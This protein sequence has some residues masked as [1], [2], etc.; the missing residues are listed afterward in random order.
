MQ[1]LHFYESL[2]KAF[3]GMENPKNVFWKGRRSRPKMSIFM[4]SSHF[5][6]NPMIA[7]K[8]ALESFFMLPSYPFSDQPYCG[9]ATLKFLH[10]FRK[11]KRGFFCSLYKK[12][13]ELLDLIA[14]SW[15]KKLLFQIIVLL[16]KGLKAVYFHY[17]ILFFFLL[18]LKSSCQQ[19]WENICYNILLQHYIG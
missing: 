16:P 12:W 19:Q 11:I 1:T 4:E 13:F 18:L 9:F 17:W 10:N 7:Q 2:W 15:K 6:W 3:F 14:F 5:L 8:K